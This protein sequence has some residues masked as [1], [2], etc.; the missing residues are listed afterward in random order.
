MFKKNQ[1][2]LQLLAR[3]LEFENKAYILPEHLVNILLLQHSMINISYLYQRNLKSWIYILVLFARP[4]LIIN[5]EYLDFLMLAYIILWFVFLFNQNFYGASLTSL[6]NTLLK[7]AIFNFVLEQMKDN[8]GISVGLFI[9][10]QQF[11][12]LLLI[13]G[14]L[15]VNTINFQVPY[16]NYLNIIDFILNILLIYFQLF[17]FDQLVIQILALIKSCF[18]FILV[19][20]YNNYRN[21]L[22]RKIVAFSHLATIVFG[23]IDFVNYQHSY[24][25]VIL[26][27][28]LKI[29]LQKQFSNHNVNDPILKASIL[30]QE[31]KVFECFIVLN[32]L[33]DL[34]IMRRA[35]SNQQMKLCVAQI[36]VKISKPNQ[37]LKGVCQQ[38]MKNDEQNILL[39]NQLNSL[40]EN[41]LSLLQNFKDLNFKQLLNYSN[42]VNSINNQLEKLHNQQN[43]MMIQSL[44]I[45]FYSEILNDLLKGQQIQSSFSTSQETQIKF[46]D[47]ILQKLIYLVANYQNNKLIVKSISS[48]APKTFCNKTLEELVPQGVREWHSLLVDKFVTDG[49]S[50]YVR[51]LN[52]N[53]I[54]NE[55]FIE[56]VQFAIDIFYTDQVDFI[57]LF[58][59]TL[60]QTKT[61][62]IN[63]DYQITSMS[64]DFS[65]FVNLSKYFKIG[66]QIDK[67][68][69][70]VTQIRESCYLENMIVMQSDQIQ[71]S[72]NFTDKRAEM[73]Y[74]C[75]VN[76]TVK[77]DNQKMLYMIIQFE[78]FKKQLIKKNEDQIVEQQQIVQKKTYEII[79]FEL[80]NNAIQDPYEF[81]EDQ[82]DINYIQNY[83]YIDEKTVAQ[84]QIF[85]PRDEEVSLVRFQRVAKRFKSQFKKSQFQ[86][87]QQAQFY[88]VQSQVSSLKQFRNS[89]FYR[90][91]EL[92]N[93]FLQYVPYYRLHKLIIAIMFLLCLYQIIFM[94]IQLTSMSLVTLSED[95]NLLEIKNLIFQPIELFLVTRW[96][97]FNY[98]NQLNE[99]LITLE[100]YTNRTGFALSNLD[101]GYDQ[102]NKNIQSVLFKKELQA[103]LEAKYFN[104][105]Q[106]LDTYK[107][108]QYNMTLRTAIQV[109]LNFQYTLKMNYKI[110]KTVAIDTPQVFYSYKN[111][112]VLNDIAQQLNLDVV[113]ETLTKANLIQRNI[114][115]ILALDQSLLLFFLLIILIL[116]QIIDRRLKQCI[117][118][119]QYVDERELELEIKKY[120]QCLNQMRLDNSYKFQYRLNLELKEQQF[121]QVQSNEIQAKIKFQ[122]ISSN[123]IVKYGVILFVIYIIFSFNHFVMYFLQNNFLYKYPETTLFLEG[124]TNL[125]VDFPCMFAQREI[126]YERKRLFYLTQ[127]DFDNVYQRII[128]ALNNTARFDSFQKDFSKILVTQKYQDYYEQLQVS[129][130]CDYIPINLK[131]KSEFICPQIFNQNMLLGLKAVLIY[132]YNLIAKEI[133]INKFTKRLIIV[134]NELDGVFILSQIIKD[135]NAQF[136]QDLKEL[137]YQ[138]VQILYIINICYIISISLIILIWI[139]KLAIRFINNSKQIIQFVQIIPSYSLFTNDQFERILRSFLNQ[140]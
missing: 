131:Q 1:F 110:E 36:I 109:L 104:A 89:K 97:L 76:I 108:E 8:L 95:I 15:T 103:L 62:I 84:Q 98:K 126:L 65:D 86:E 14:T 57:C 20:F 21:S 52:N 114:E 30:L 135:V 3:L 94:I 47:S 27:L 137:T 128:L 63:Q 22:I 100:E 2:N 102:L 41:K 42:K 116:Q 6:F 134:Y 125:G 7:T 88:D 139:P 83:L 140:K 48:N 39:S 129:N 120:Q 119:K 53:Y 79:P 77:I 34:G 99:K 101:L 74:Y 59:P 45:F 91:Y 67:F 49:E 18:Q 124:I 4:Q 132:S 16:S 87:E 58:Q 107:N 93:K 72:K 11:F 130:L 127:E 92:Y 24:T 81:S 111:Y 136:V 23:I 60:L 38:L 5:I 66:Q 85:T 33:K 69:P 54:A 73:N 17:K 117:N 46:N 32:N 25:L 12:D 75:D 106:Y 10:I 68:I 138:L 64:S 82:Q 29:I 43:S 9:S 96:T 40:I 78:N 70:S 55:N 37:A 123:F 71:S 112:K 56:N 51:N 50:K 113:Q 121:Q 35:K 44:Q 80:E 28:L 115:T 90:K 118:L 31:G 61:V 122:K 13:Q 133:E 105:Y 19:I 26:P